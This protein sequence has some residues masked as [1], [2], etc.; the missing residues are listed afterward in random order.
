MDENKGITKG[1]VVFVAILVR[2][3]KR[4]IRARKPHL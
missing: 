2:A 1:D 4:K 3:I